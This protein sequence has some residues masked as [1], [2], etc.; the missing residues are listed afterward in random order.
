MLKLWNEDLNKWQACQLFIS[1][2]IN[3]TTS[4]L[5][6]NWNIFGAKTNHGH[7]WIHKIHRDLDLGEATTFPFIVFSVTTTGLHSNDIFPRIPKLRI[8]QFPKLGLLPLWTPITSYVDLQL[9]WGL[10]Q[11]CRFHWEFSNNISHASCTHVT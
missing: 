8:A 5:V 11:S 3:Q 4:L 7:T 2:C 9:R 1:I 10:K 6:H